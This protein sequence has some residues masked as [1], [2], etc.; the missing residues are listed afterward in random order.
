MKQSLDVAV[1][2][3]M[4]TLGAE[5]ARVEQRLAAATK[6]AHSPL[7]REPLARVLGSKGKRLRPTLVLAVAAH[8]S[9]RVSNA[10][11]H[12]AAALELAHIASLV[13]D[14]IID[15]AASRRGVPTIN[16]VEGVNHAILGGD[17]LFAQ[18]CAEGARASA[19]VGEAVAQGIIAL[20]DGESQ[21]VTS[22]HNQART[23]DELFQAMAGKTAALFATACRVGGLCG[24]ASPEHV[25][26]L[27]AY[28]R[29]LGMA[30]QLVDDLLDLLSTAKISGKPVGND[31]REGVYTLPIILALSGP[32]RHRIQVWLQ[33]PQDLPH[34]E[35]VDLLMHEGYI[36]QTVRL[37]QQYNAAAATAMQ[38][39]QGSNGLA[40]LPETYTRWALHQMLAPNYRAALAEMSAIIPA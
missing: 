21:E 31:I 18:A 34:E 25:V 5:L 22:E 37:A 32:Q 3:G 8:Y 23:Q 2:L 24:N 1:E 36:E 33:N 9:G 39:A 14:D 20:C 11:V 7:L 15:N 29:N 17:V 28:G 35:L 6:L 30:F 13:H 10:T 16:S 27:E 38:Q 12:A 26:A 40:A 4:P 19:A